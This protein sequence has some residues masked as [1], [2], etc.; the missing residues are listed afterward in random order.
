MLHEV[1]LAAILVEYGEAHPALGQGQFL[2]GT[3]IEAARAVEHLAAID[4]LLR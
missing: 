4:R 2:D 1:E 3:S